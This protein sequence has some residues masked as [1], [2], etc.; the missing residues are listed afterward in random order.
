LKIEISELNFLKINHKVKE[1]VEIEAT[2]EI[3]EIEVAVVVVREEAEEEKEEEILDRLKVEVE[4]IETLKKEE[5][6]VNKLCR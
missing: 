1:V 3:E 5:E 6:E 2:E 4:G